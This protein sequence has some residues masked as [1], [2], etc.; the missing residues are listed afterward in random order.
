[1]PQI[2]AAVAIVLC[3]SAVIDLRDINRQDPIFFPCN[4]IDSEW[5]PSMQILSFM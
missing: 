5:Y 1:M 3:R 2:H 4:M